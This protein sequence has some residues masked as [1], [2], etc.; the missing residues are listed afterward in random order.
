MRDGV[1][2]ILYRCGGFGF[3]SDI[4]GALPSFEGG[5]RCFILSTPQEY[6]WTNYFKVSH[7]KLGSQGG[8]YLVGGGTKVPT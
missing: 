7:G 1:P 6:R 2:Q 3:M 5:A 8:I 4:S